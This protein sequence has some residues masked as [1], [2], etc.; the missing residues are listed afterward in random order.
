VLD[1]AEHQESKK[2]LLKQIGQLYVVVAGKQAVPVPESARKTRKE[3]D[4]QSVA[5]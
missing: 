3:A 5:E 4:D 1:H 2:G